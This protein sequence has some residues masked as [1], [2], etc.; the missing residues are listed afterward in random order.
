VLLQAE[1]A[2]MQAGDQQV[3]VGP[4]VRHYVGSS[5]LSRGSD[6]CTCS[7]PDPS[8]AVATAMA[9]M[10]A[11][12]S[13]ERGA[14]SK[15]RTFNDPASVLETMPKFSFLEAELTGSCSTVVDGDRRADM[16]ASQEC[17]ESIGSGGPLVTS[18]GGNHRTFRSL[19]QQQLSRSALHQCGQP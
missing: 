19:R 7:T 13:A 10:P 16:L 6:A 1:E 14:K 2:G 11:G 8:V 18:L 4:S 17:Q 9:V 15:G 5:P 12:S 3:R